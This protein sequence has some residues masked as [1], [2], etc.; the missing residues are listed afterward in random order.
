MQQLRDGNG[1]RVFTRSEWLDPI[2]IKA[3]FSKFSAQDRRG[4]KQPVTKEDVEDEVRQ[5]D[6]ATDVLDAQA[7]FDEI[8]EPPGELQHPIH[9]SNTIA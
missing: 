5:L 9:V 4:S 8:N 3:L 1:L 2:Q 6:A 7:L